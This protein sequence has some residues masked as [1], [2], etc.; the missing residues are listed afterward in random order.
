VQLGIMVNVNR[1]D[2][3]LP[4][5]PEKRDDL[6][7]RLDPLLA[8]ARQSDSGIIRLN[9]FARDGTI[10]YSDLASLRGRVVP[11]LSDELLASALGGA[12]NAEVTQ[13]SAPENADLGPR[14][15]SALEAYVPCVLGGRVAGVYE[16]YVDL[17]VIR[18]IQAIVWTS[19][20]IVF[21]VPLLGI[22]V[23]ER[24]RGRRGPAARPV[25]AGAR[26]Q[27]PLELVPAGNNGAEGSPDDRLDG[28]P[29]AV[30]VSVKTPT[31]YWLT[32][33]E[34][35]VLH[36]LATGR[37]YR[38]IASELLLSE[39]TVRSHVKHILRKLAEPDRSRAVASA[40]RA[41]ILPR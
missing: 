2:F 26:L 35:E 30:M 10:L 3:E 16:V 27:A 8:R 20:A 4:F 38:Q 23:V 1:A 29:P 39:E 33:R 34:M 28:I 9:L 21:G 18:P 5:T 24:G 14:Y 31:G 13:L 32:R 22:L 15:G 19:T 36:L 17:D 40:V 41:G 7:A 6:A 37:T 12:A 25:P 11:L